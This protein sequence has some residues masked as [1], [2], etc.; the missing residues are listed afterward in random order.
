M[1]RIVSSDS[2][3]RFSSGLHLPQ[4][5]PYNR[6]SIDRVYR[7]RIGANWRDVKNDRASINDERYENEYGRSF[8]DT[9]QQLY[10]PRTRR[11]SFIDDYR[12]DDVESYGD[13]SR[14]ERLPENNNEN[15]YDDELEF[16]PNEKSPDYTLLK[17]TSSDDT[18]E[19][20]YE[21]TFSRKYKHRKQLPLLEFL[22]NNPT[23]DNTKDTVIG[24]DDL[25]YDDE[26]VDGDSAKIEKSDASTKAGRMYTEGGVVR[27]S[28][29]KSA[30]DRSGG[31]FVIPRLILLDRILNIF[32]QLIYTYKSDAETSETYDD[33]LDDELD[34]L[35]W[36]RELAGFKRRERLD[37]KKPGPLFATNNYAFKTQSTPSK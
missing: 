16:S 31:E 32:A 27:P 33:V 14:N 24:R 20:E 22:D 23:T 2:T 10:L 19:K 26:A 9:G 30:L 6:E 29:H 18:D 17:P 12:N 36:R 34:E 35:L 15:L 4:A 37:V 3:Y 13:T 7:H 11:Y 21:R 1:L 8:S 28:K 5:L 25:D